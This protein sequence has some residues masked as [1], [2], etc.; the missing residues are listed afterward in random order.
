MAYSTVMAVMGI[1]FAVISNLLGLVFFTFCRQ[2]YRGCFSQ[3]VQ[4]PSF[5][6]KITI[7]A[8]LPRG[9]FTQKRRGCYPLQI[10]SRA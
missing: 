8:P 1:S 9:F 3:M 2:S 5:H 10:T 6:H 4:P 7:K